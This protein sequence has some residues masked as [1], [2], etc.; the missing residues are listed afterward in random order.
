MY[1][2]DLRMKVIN[3]IQKGNTQK[4]AVEVFCINKNTISSWWQRYR[5]DG[6]VSSKSMKGAK[7]SIDKEQFIDFIKSNSD[8]R[9]SDIAAHFNLSQGGAFYWLKKLKFVFKKKTSP[10]WRQMKQEGKNI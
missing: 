2:K 5:Q 10:T 3:F 1:G 4:Q 6:C 9:V 7:P 8:A